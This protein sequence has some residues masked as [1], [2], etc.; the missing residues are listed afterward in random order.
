MEAFK[1][2]YSTMFDPPAELHARFDAAVAELRAN[3]LRRSGVSLSV[4]GGTP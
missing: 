4:S 2:T 1:L 3:L